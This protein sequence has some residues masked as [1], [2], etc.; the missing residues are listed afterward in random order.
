M[1][2][3]KDYFH[4]IAW[5][6]GL[7]YIA[8][9]VITF[10][11]L[12]HGPSVFGGSGVCRP[13]DAKVL[14]YWVCDPAHPLAVMAGVANTA[15]TATVW[16][17]VY[18]AAA[19]VRPEAIM[20]ALPIVGTHVVGLPTAIFVTIRI[21]LALLALPRRLRRGQP[22]EAAAD[23]DPARVNAAPAC[24]APVKPRDSFGLR[25]AP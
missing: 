13:D 4:F 24:R 23:P 10:L 15:L 21:M 22:P 6:A 9:W 16:A 2:R 3:L 7:G 18:I 19:T 5:E 12:D 14:F 20:L 8:L 11:T 1:R 25:A 17:P